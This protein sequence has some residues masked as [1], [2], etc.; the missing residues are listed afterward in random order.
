MDTFFGVKCGK[1]I[2]SGYFRVEIEVDTCE[3]DLKRRGGH[4]KHRQNTLQWILRKKNGK[5]YP[6]S[7]SM[8]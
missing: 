4:K 8:R 6:H 3:N 7:L 5:L 2:Q 1:W